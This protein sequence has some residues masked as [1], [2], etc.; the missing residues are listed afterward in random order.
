MKS[1]SPR[2]SACRAGVGKTQSS[3]AAADR[4]LLLSLISGSLLLD[5]SMILVVS[6]YIYSMA[7][8]KE[9]SKL[10]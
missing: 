6:L 8:G 1:I 3:V 5:P 10:L 9:R 4:Q 2:V 7:L